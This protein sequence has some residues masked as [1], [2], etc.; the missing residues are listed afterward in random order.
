[1]TQTLKGMVGS[2]GFAKGQAVWRKRDATTIKEMCV[3]DTAQELHHLEMAIAT[4]KQQIL[5]LRYIAVE[6]M[7][8]EEAMIFD[9]HLSFLDDP[10]FTGEMKNRIKNEKKNAEA[11]CE[12]VVA[13]MCN[14]FQSLDDEYMRARAED[15]RDVGSRLLENMER[16]QHLSRSLPPNSIVIAYDLTPSDTVQFS[17]EIIGIITSRGSKNSHAAIIARTLGIPAIFGLN[18]AIERIKDGD[19]LLLDGENGTIYINPTHET[20]QTLME[21]MRLHSIHTKNALREAAQDTYTA[22]KKRIKIFANIGNTGDIHAALSNHAEGVGLFRTEFLYIENTHWPTE[23]E[24]FNVYTQVLRA[25]PTRTVIIRTLDIGGDKQL[26]YADLAN[27]DNPYLGCRGI[28]FCLANKK[29]FETQL[30]AL[31]RASVHGDLWVLLPMIENVYQIKE[32][33]S[34]LEECKGDLQKQGIPV[35]ADLKLGIMIEIPAA[36]LTANILAKEVDFFSI[37]TNDL[38]QYT[39][40][41]DRGNEHVRHLYDETHPAV[42]RLIEMICADAQKENI[43]V[44][45]CGELASNLAVT[46]ALI[47]MG[48][49]KLSVSPYTIPKV[50]QTV[51]K[52]NFQILDKIYQ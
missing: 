33:K 1:M 7:G 29:I 26:S 40:A 21:Q 11:I 13:E 48:I 37:G 12:V 36:A 45:I 35:N 4:T 8:E 19:H 10:S 17:S 43:P 5:E 38:T 42:F 18:G 41:A 27:E 49:E 22:D 52:S 3:E 30:R 9:A 15:I 32:T 50:K 39:L 16:K 44:G 25:F 28:R 51:R 24:Q 6:R 2:S 34:L 47:R 46:E 23:E 31:L 14:L 20:E